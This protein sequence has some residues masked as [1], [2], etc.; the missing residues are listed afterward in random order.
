MESKAYLDIET[1]FRGDITVAGILVPPR[2]MVQLIGGE[3]NG[4]NMMNVLT[5]ASSIVTYNG[6]RFDLP[7][8]RKRIGLDLSSRFKS[9]DLMYDC[10]REGLYG[11]LKI[12]EQKLGIKRETVGLTGS[13]APILWERYIVDGDDEALDLLLQYNREDVMN[14][15]FLEEML[16]GLEAEKKGGST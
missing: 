10:R 8:I 16:R 5:P 6:S 1:S 4:H 2:N 14:L 9:L 11:G 13:D 15:V 7:V 12:V 3:V